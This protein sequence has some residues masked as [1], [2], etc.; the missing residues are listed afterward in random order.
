MH[1]S[2]SIAPLDTATTD[3]DAEAAR[4]TARAAHDPAARAEFV[5]LCLPLARRLA[6][7]YRGKGEPFADLE[8]V[9]R[10]GLV[11]AVD[12]YDAERGSFTAFAVVTILGELRK[13]FRDRTWGVRAPRRLQDLVVQ[14]RQAGSELTNTLSRAPSSTELADRLH[15]TADEVDEAMQSAAGYALLSLNAPVTG[16]D[17]GSDSAERGDLIG[18]IDGDLAAI[19][20]RLAI[21]SLLNRLPERER[22]I[23]ILRF[24]GNLTQTEIAQRCGISQMHV[25]RLLS[26]TLTWLRH[27]LLSDAPPHWGDVDEGGLDTPRLRLT[28]TPAGNGALTV[29]VG[30]E[31]DRDSADEL[32]QAILNGLARR[33]KALNLDL[34]GVP[35]MDAAA[36][37]AL[38]CGYQESRRAAVDLRLR[39]IQPHV[40]RI[41]AAARLPFLDGPGSERP[42]MTRASAQP[43]HH[44][45]AHQLRGRQGDQVDR[46][47]QQVQQGRPVRQGRL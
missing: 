24:Y 15:V 33:P 34:S 45:A 21:A 26:R 13:H 3:L 10:L 41:L 19:D 37:A 1:V 16:R 29:A 39:G 46:D 42:P 28:T 43:A 18:E 44:Q 30:G 27:A 2:H 32:R 9:A 7:R 6:L 35:F 20:D 12:R 8:Q 38:V 5:E 14:M 25:S 11:K 22:Q 23:L 31:I 17:G 36:V 40:R 47:P 4:Y